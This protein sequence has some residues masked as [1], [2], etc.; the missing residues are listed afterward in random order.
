MTVTALIV[1][2]GKGLRAGGEVPKQYQHVG[3]VMLL[4]HAVLR[5]Q[6]HGGV[7]TIRVVINPAD[8]DLYDAAVAGLALAAPIAGG[9]TRQAS[10]R[11]GLEALA[12]DPPDLVLVHDAARAFVPDAV[13]DALLAALGDPA[14]DGAV[15]AL[16][17]TDSLRRGT[18]HY[19]AAVDRDGLWR[20][21]TPQA[22]RYPALVAA[23][24]AAA[25]GATD[26]LAI[27]MAA[28]LRVA[29]TPGDERAFKVTEPADFAKATAMVTPALTS[30]AAGGF[31]VHR[32]GP[33]DHVWLCGVQIPHSHGLVG[34]SDAD[35]GLHA[36]T[37]ALL[38]TIA[39]GDIGDHFPPSD[40]QWKGAASDRFLAHAATLV[41]AAGGIIDHVDV[42]LICERPKI[43]PHREAMR[44]RIAAILDIS[45]T[46]VSVKATTTELLGFTGRSEG[47]AAQAMASV[48]LPE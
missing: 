22:F 28:G 42:T 15:P 6:A 14:N 36:L 25:A 40:P 13:L 4:R 37:D 39:A 23:H 20:V 35:A 10:A 47:L 21:Q 46:R 9:D 19:D 16:A 45:A 7:D 1:A 5:L 33:G 29:I 31:D 17:V 30:R 32:F 41:R 38:G 24:R 48:R 43:G 26:E 27:A 44:D 12:A 18:D 34:H 11:A 2:A 8:R 3:G